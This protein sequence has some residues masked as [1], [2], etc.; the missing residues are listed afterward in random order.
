MTLQTGVS[1]RPIAIAIVDDEGSVRVGLRR[2]CEALGLKPTVY[3]SG[4]AFLDSLGSDAPAPDCLL[5]D[6]Q[7]PDM[8][9]LEVHQHLA[10]RG[11]SFP[12]GVYTGDDAREMHA[13]YLASG[14]AGL[15]RKPISADE[16]LAAIE[17]ALGRSR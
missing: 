9:G 6:A 13:R 4:Q 3:A 10:G 2:L 1:P 7:M 17:R 11:V 5:L 12:T 16:L 15:L 14:V 8:T